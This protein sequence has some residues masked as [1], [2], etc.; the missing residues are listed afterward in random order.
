MTKLEVNLPANCS[1]KACIQISLSNAETHRLEYPCLAGTAGIG[2]GLPSRRGDFVRQQD[3][4]RRCLQRGIVVVRRR[5]A[6]HHVVNALPQTLGVGK[7]CGRR[8]QIAPRH[9]ACDRHYTFGAGAFRRSSSEDAKNVKTGKDAV[10]RYALPNPAPASNVFTVRPNKDTDIQRGI[11][12][13]AFGQPGG[14]VEVIF[15]NGT[16]PKTVTGPMKIPDE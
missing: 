6:P 9:L 15:T 1:A 10:A 11:V 5:A 7:K 16:Q 2:D 12:E 14:G 8:N 13:P 4:A 3:E